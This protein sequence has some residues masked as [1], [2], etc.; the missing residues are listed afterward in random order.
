MANGVRA[1]KDVSDPGA[2]HR[3]A[4][5]A[6]PWR[7]HGLN[8]V[9]GALIGTVETVPGVSG[10]TVALVVGVYETLITSAGH[11][12]SGI[13][14]T[15]TDGVRGRGLTRARTEFATADWR[16]IF[17][18]LVGMAVALVV[19]ARLIEGWVEESPVESRALFF[20]LV[21]ASVWVP[22]TL[23]GQASQGRPGRPGDPGV[24]EAVRSGP[25][26]WTRAEVAIGIAAAALAFIVVS[27]PPGNVES[28]RVIIMLAAA[29]AV[30]ALILPGLSGS[31]LLLTFGM[32]EETLSAVN[33]RDLG[34]L[35]FFALGAASGLASF[36]KLLQWLL[37]R[38]RR[39]TLIVLTGVMVG[40]LR[41]LWPWQDEDRVLEAP[42]E[43][44]A[45]AAGLAALGFLAVLA[46]LVLERRWVASRS[47]VNQG[48]SP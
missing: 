41:A 12:L 29:I 37:E 27:I 47:A 17:P 14:H 3:R 8:A 35:A 4:T 31:F 45:A 16:V 24:S 43:H 25:A 2:R 21:L 7:A 32:Y 13:R 6:R 28:N 15:V 1:N 46:F 5:D 11:V 22:F 20:G 44:V 33:E 42:D 34:Y 18:I 30:S 9:R 23:V 38:R 26:R 10:G 39:I 40:C 36:V 19:M 48:L